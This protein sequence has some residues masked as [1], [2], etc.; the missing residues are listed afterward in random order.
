MLIGE[1]MEQTPSVTAAENMASR[2]ADRIRN[3]WLEKKAS[4]T[5]AWEEN[6]F[7]DA[8]GISF[9][10]DEG[11][12]NLQGID[13]IFRWWG[14]HDTDEMAGDLEVIWKVR[15]G[16]EMRLFKTTIRFANR[17]FILAHLSGET[18]KREATRADFRHAFAIWQKLY[19]Q[20]AI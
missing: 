8:D 14:S 9:L 11:F 18:R 16:G 12:P 6:F 13:Y 17:D 5:K 7:E 19:Q 15:K 4:G 10:R 2:L 3:I 1:V 20:E